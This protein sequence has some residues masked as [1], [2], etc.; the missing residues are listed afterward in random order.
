MWLVS[1]SDV[2]LVGNVPLPQAGHLELNS[3]W[4]V[5][6]TQL[7]INC[8]DRGIW[9]LAVLPTNNQSGKLIKMFKA[10]IK[11]SSHKPLINN[12]APVNHQ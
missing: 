11:A 4:L 1:S 5:A 12:D 2:I 10:I 3:P 7:L 6:I 8:A 9:I